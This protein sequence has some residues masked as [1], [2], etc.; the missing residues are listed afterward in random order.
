MNSKSPQEQ[1]DGPRASLVVKLKKTSNHRNAACKACQL[2]KSRCEFD[3]LNLSTSCIRCMQKEIECVMPT[4]ISKRRKL[5]ISADPTTSSR[6]SLEPPTQSPKTPI[7]VNLENQLLSGLDTRDQAQNTRLQD[8]SQQRSSATNSEQPQATIEKPPQASPQDT[9]ATP[10]KPNSTPHSSNDAPPGM[11]LF[12][13]SQIQQVLD[14]YDRRK[15]RVQFLEAQVDDLEQTLNNPTQVADQD[16]CEPTS[17]NAAL[18]QQRSLVAAL[19]RALVRHAKVTD[20]NALY[21]LLEDLGIDQ[22]HYWALYDNEEFRK[23]FPASHGQE[24]SRSRSR[25]AEGERAEESPLQQALDAVN[26][27]TPPSSSAKAPP[28]QPRESTTT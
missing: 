17:S 26:G 21:N 22:S 28:N 4:P 3:D 11:M 20:L 1:H 16:E 6:K 15:Q 24:T 14:I 19:G 2:L 25:G 12:P 8:E 5:S 13:I 10:S 9:S 7:A 23:S 18:D 27:T